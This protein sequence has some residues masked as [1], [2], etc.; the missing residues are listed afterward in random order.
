M[1]HSD[2]ICELNQS[3]HYKKRL[4]RM[5]HEE[6]AASLVNFH[7]PADELDRMSRFSVTYGLF[8]TQS[9]CMASEDLRNSTLAIWI[10]F[11]MVLW[12]IFWQLAQSLSLY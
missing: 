3:I 6:I 10:I 9:Y 12:C 4:K 5:S 2:Q 8:L 11:M 7:K 1:K